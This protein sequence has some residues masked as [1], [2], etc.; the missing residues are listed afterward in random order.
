MENQ[1]LIYLIS[2]W[3]VYKALHW[4]KSVSDFTTKIIL[5]YPPRHWRLKSGHMYQFIVI[6]QNKWSLIKLFENHT[7]V[8]HNNMLILIFNMFL[9]GVFI[10]TLVGLLIAL[11]TLAFEV[12]YFKHKRGRVDSAEAVDKTVPQ[13]DQ[14][15]Y[16]HELFVGLGRNSSLDDRKR[17]A[18]KIKLDSTTTRLNNALFYRRHKFQN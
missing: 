17:W 10:A 6:S 18:S 11:I 13:K 15:M 4:I 14:L 2:H 3:R 9:G 12:V 7:N 5:R 1:T 16:G 8:Q